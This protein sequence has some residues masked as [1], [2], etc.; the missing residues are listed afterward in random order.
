[1]SAKYIWNLSDN[2]QINYDRPNESLY[3]EYKRGIWSINLDGHMKREQTLNS[4][5]VQV[6]RAN[7][8]VC[9]C[10]Y[11]C[12]L[13]YS[14]FFPIFNFFFFLIL[15]QCTLHP[16][17]FNRYF[18]ELRRAYNTFFFFSTSPRLLCKLPRFVYLLYSLFT[19]L[20]FYVH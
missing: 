8:Y 15:L 20:S 16:L 3:V 9:V 4:F 5:D 19:H 11:V 14:S 10:L 17:S 13:Y 7:V 12:H 1:M 18:Y 2:H 6:V